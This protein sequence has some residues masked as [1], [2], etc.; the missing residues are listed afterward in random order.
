MP[1]RLSTRTRE[2]YCRSSSTAFRRSSSYSPAGKSESTAEWVE[3]IVHASALSDER[4]EICRV[5]RLETVVAVSVPSANET[6]GRQIPV[7]IGMMYVARDAPPSAGAQLFRYATSRN[8]LKPS[9]MRSK[10]PKASAGTTN[11]MATSAA[12]KPNVL[13]P[14]VTPPSA[15][16]PS[17]GDA[18]STSGSKQVSSWVNCSSG[19]AVR[20]TSAGR[21]GRATAL[22]A[23][24]A[25]ASMP[26]TS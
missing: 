16:S 9:V 18:S 5:R 3:R 2:Q 26:A 13:V 1:A 24:A 10:P 19:E 11:G 8:A 22:A 25:T 6:A 20:R 14:T 17:A 7:R 12:S 21:M 23:S 15:S 4:I